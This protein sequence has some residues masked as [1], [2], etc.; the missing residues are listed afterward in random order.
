M[1]THDERDE[2]QYSKLSPVYDKV[3]P[4]GRGFAGFTIFF[5]DGEFENYIRFFSQNTHAEVLVA[6]KD[7]YR[8]WAATHHNIKS[9][10]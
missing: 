4:D 10:E 2:P 9:E 6:V 1:K 8:Q 5:Q 7:E 3:F